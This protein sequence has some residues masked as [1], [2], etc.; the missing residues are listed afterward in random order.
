[1]NKQ[2]DINPTKELTN[3]NDNSK[4]DNDIQQQEQAEKI[5]SNEHK[6]A[7]S[8][9]SNKSTGSSNS[10][11][12]NSDVDKNKDITITESTNDTQ[13][14]NTLSNTSNESVN[15]LSAEDSLIIDTSNNQDECN[16]G[17]SN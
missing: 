12:N 17:S 14:T 5:C 4:I 8:A 2:S 15:I 7:D 13:L 6:I 10:Y 1:M 11:E 16:T 9:S 3:F